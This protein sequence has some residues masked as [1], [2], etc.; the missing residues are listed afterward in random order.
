M[1]ANLLLKNLSA[2]YKGKIVFS[3]LN[4]T[5]YRGR[6]N[7]IVGRAGAGKSTLL[8]TI[9]G[10]N[11]AVDGKILLD[12]IVFNPAGKVSLAFQNPE[13]LFF[14]ATVM[15]EAGYALKMSSLGPAQIEEKTGVWLKR[16]GL[17]PEIYGKR[18]PL[19]LSGGEKRR[20]ALAACTICAPPVILLDEPLAGIDHVGQKQIND[21]ILSLCENHIV[22]VV[23][24]D[25][26]ALLA[27]ASTVLF[28]NGEKS[29]WFDGTGFLRRAVK[30]SS[31]FPIAHWYQEA[32]RQHTDASALPAVD[33]HDVFNFLQKQAGKNA[34]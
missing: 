29:E 3:C 5:F 7:L 18:H 2:G 13:N 8:K 10:F 21:L 27:K 17:D 32:I 15:E 9:A 22:I 16:W 31:F 28:L 20:L 30:D 4:G 19:A 6:P 26:E 24:H 14:N 1:S 12:D 11:Q 33:P 23:T 34:D 25:P